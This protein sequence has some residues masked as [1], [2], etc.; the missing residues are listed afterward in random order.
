MLKSDQD[1]ITKKRWTPGRVAFRTKLERE[2]V[3][4]ARGSR[5]REEKLKEDAAAKEL[6]A[7]S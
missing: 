7:T 5:K 4:L 3:T 6:E 2:Q 1:G